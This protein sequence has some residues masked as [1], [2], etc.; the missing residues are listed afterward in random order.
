MKTTLFLGFGVLFW[1]SGAPA[2]L[3]TLK[4]SVHD[5]LSEICISESTP[6]TVTKRAS[7]FR[8]PLLS[9]KGAQLNITSQLPNPLQSEHRYDFVDQRICSSGRGNLVAAQLREYNPFP[10]LLRTAAEESGGGDM[11]KKGFVLVELSRRTAA[12]LSPPDFQLP[13]DSSAAVQ[14]PELP[15]CR[16]DG[17][18][19]GWTATRLLQ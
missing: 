12:E 15:A 8:R 14:L 4:K 18:N 17:F 3:Q 13:E 9:R 19:G 6:P 5:F 2:C 1:V 11:D 7:R 16:L 10:S